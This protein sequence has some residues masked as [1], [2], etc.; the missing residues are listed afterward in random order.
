MNGRS[1][2]TIA[3]MDAKL[4]EIHA[5]LGDKVSPEY[6]DM[7][8]AVFEYTYDQDHKDYAGARKNRNLFDKK[9]A[10]VKKILGLS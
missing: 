8:L 1:L 3:E 5:I 2:K 10:S 7:K 4:A 9:Y 6:E